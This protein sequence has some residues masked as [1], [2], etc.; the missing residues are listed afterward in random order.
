MLRICKSDLHSDSPKQEGSRS[1]QPSS[2][3]QASTGLHDNTERG[4]PVIMGRQGEVRGSTLSGKAGKRQKA[5]AMAEG[6]YGRVKNTRCSYDLAKWYWKEHRLVVVPAERG[7]KHPIGKWAHIKSF[8]E[9]LTYWG[10]NDHGKHKP[11]E[12]DFNWACITGLSNVIVVDH[13]YKDDKKFNE[14][15]ISNTFTVETP[16]GYHQYVRVP[17]LQMANSVNAERKIDIRAEG[18]IA[19]LPPSSSGH[20]L[21][22]LKN[23]CDIREVT[24]GEFSDYIKALGI[25]PSESD[26]GSRNEPGWWSIQYEAGVAQGERNNVLAKMSG[27]LINKGLTIADTLAIL[28]AWSYSHIDPPMEY[29]EIEQ[30]VKSI[31]SKHEREK[32]DGYVQSEEEEDETLTQAEANPDNRFA[33]DS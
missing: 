23:D 32:A 1:R 5:K 3:V 31:F 7:K 30:T 24:E 10:E 12:L 16:K 26:K 25:L 2:D 15:G 14:L 27:Y 29:W 22:Q 9:A 6:H 4:H 17:N 28:H 8:E 21:Y 18:G 13:D 11:N 19:I 20:G 33:T